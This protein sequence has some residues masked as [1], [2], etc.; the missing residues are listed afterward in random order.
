MQSCLLLH[1]HRS[2]SGVIQL[3]RNVMD[4]LHRFLGLLS[5]SFADKA[6]VFY[7][8]GEGEKEAWAN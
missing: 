8:G 4:G 6:F 3:D 2:H 7:F 1:F 5:P